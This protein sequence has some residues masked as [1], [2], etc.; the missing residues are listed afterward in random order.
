MYVPEQ[1][2]RKAKEENEPKEQNQPTKKG[3]WGE[4]DGRPNGRNEIHHRTLFS[5]EFE[6]RVLFPL[7][8]PH[9]DEVVPLEHPLDLAVR[10]AS[11]RNNV[12]SC[13]SVRCTCNAP[14]CR[15]IQSKCMLQEEAM[16]G[17]CRALKGVLVN[18]CKQQWF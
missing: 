16:A 13:R 1:Q 5:G 6:L 8:P 3:G 11:V 12:R 17:S 4:G 15:V 9:L 2:K 14:S 18:R 7:S 10:L